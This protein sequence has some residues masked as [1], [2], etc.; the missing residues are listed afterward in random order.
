MRNVFCMPRENENDFITKGETNALTKTT[1]AIALGLGLNKTGYP[2]QSTEIWNDHKYKLLLPATW[3]SFILQH[4]IAR[5]DCKT[6]P[7]EKIFRMGCFSLLSSYSSYR[8]SFF[9]H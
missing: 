8:F 1:G 6:K 2:L 9:D 5:V 7:R 4:D 3:Q